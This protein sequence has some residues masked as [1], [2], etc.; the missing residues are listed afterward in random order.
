MDDDGIDIFKD[1][2]GVLG[3]LGFYV[4]DKYFVGGDDVGDISDEFFVIF[5]GCVG[6]G[7]V[8]IDVVV[9]V[10][11]GGL[12]DGVFDIFDGGGWVDGEG[13]R[14]IFDGFFGS[15]RVKVSGF[16]S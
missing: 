10:D 16:C 12:G 13:C 11:V 7:I 4:F 3:N 14:E 2:D 8:D 15:Y 1:E 9:V 5:V 6:G